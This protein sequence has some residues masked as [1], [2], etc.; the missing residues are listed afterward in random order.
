MSDFDKWWNSE[1]ATAS[2]EN[3]DQRGLAKA[4][5][6]AATVAAGKVADDLRAENERL[7][8]IL[9]SNADALVIGY[10]ATKERDL[11]RTV[12]EQLREALRALSW[13][14]GW[15]P[16]GG[17]CVCKEHRAAEAALAAAAPLLEPKETP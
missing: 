11:L 14:H 9:E 4:A 16:Q 7:R 3:D 2:A 10:E 8:K 1:D 17:P 12:A 5:W 6:D 15:I 13:R